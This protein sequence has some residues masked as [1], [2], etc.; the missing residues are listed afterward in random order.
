MFSAALER[1]GLKKSTRGSKKGSMK[2]EGDDDELEAGIDSVWRDSSDNLAGLV[3]QDDKATATKPVALAA[4]TVPTV[5]AV[6]AV[7]ATAGTL[8]Y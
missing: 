6:T 1:A 3:A 5:T 2:S 8:F 4:P 7:T